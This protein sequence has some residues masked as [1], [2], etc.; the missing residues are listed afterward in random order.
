MA[1]IGKPL[2]QTRLLI[3][4]FLLS[5]NIKV[6]EASD[7]LLYILQAQGPAIPPD[8]STSLN[9]KSHTATLEFLLS[10][11]K[12]FDPSQRWVY[13]QEKHGLLERA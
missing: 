5:P 12:D 13:D 9:P 2:M 8:P 10:F 3:T 6:L 11:I 4:F 1:N 7:T